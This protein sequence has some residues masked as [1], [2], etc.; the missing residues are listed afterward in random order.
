MPSS[1]FQ[2]MQPAP[3]NGKQTP[4]NIQQIRNLMNIVRNSNNPMAMLMSL[5]GYQNVVPLIQ[6]Y[7]DP[8]SAFYALAQQK[9]VDPDSI[10][11]LLK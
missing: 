9:G 7:G 5:P 8:K 11:S 6:Q 2:T 10:L 1:L 3:T 4:N